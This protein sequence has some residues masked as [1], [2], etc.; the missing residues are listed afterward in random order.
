MSVTQIHFVINN[1]YVSGM[2]AQS[3]FV[4]WG[5]SLEQEH[6]EDL[7]TLTCNDRCAFELV[8]IFQI[9]AFQPDSLIYAHCLEVAQAAGIAISRTYQ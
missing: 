9:A 3:H 7:I 8:R 6:N 2:A 4:E 1:E 5:L